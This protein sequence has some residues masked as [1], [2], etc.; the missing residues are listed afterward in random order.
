MASH[1]KRLESVALVEESSVVLLDQG[2]VYMLSILQR[3]LPS[4]SRDRS[5]GVFRKYWANAL[6]AWSC[7][8]SCVVVL[9]ASNGE[10]RCF[11]P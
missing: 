5:D 3:A 4:D 6:E 2:A 9:E 8:L 1:P 10:R 11:F 7:R